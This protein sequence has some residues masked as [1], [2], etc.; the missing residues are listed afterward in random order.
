MN[1]PGGDRTF[2]GGKDRGRRSDS[3]GS[4]PRRPGQGASGQGASGHGGSGHGASG[5][6]GSKHGGSKP[7]GS[8]HGGSKHGAAERSDAPRSRGSSHRDRDHGPAPDPEARKRQAKEREERAWKEPVVRPAQGGEDLTAR[9]AAIHLLILWDL[10]KRAPMETL[11]GEYL[12]GV[13]LSPSDRGFLTEL[14]YGAVRQRSTLRALSEHFLERPLNETHRSLRAA[15]GIGL[16]QRVYL[17]TPPHAV[18]DATIEGWRSLAP[19]PSS[20]VQVDGAAGLLNAVLRRACESI[21][22][23]PLNTEPEDPTEVVRAGDRW[24]HVPGLG[25]PEHHRAELLGVQYSHPTEM[26]RLWLERYDTATLRRILERNNRTPQL[27]IAPRSDQ[28][29]EAFL[30]L[31]KVGGIEAT[32]VGDTDLPILRILTPTPIERIPGFANGSFWVQDRT[33]RRLAAMMP[34]RKGVTLL[35]LCAAPG[36]KLATLLDRGG[37]ERVVACDVSEEK[38]R[39]LA[40]NLTRLRFE[41]KGIGLVEISRE[42]ERLRFDMKFD[43]I[44]VD[45]PCSNTGVLARRHEARW[46]F[47]PEEM[48]SLTALQH[49][50]LEAAVRHL[51]PGGDLLY[52]TCSIEPSENGDP[53][54]DLLARHT[55]VRLVEEVEVLPGDEDGDGGYGALLRRDRG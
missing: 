46:R 10:R 13:Q 25:L 15:L 39:R 29:P 31:L 5:H 37:I 35:D 48:R 28:E 16:Y 17:D 40:E 36:G 49:G 45:A 52:T 26:V 4:A 9:A 38:L 7:G 6:G 42:S 51:A 41:S 8:K 1:R 43:Q 24:V 50:L 47:L 23:L 34:H 11:L 27:F 18:V 30:R 2:G 54:H 44:L 33:A 20:K 14:C 12:D 32:Q 53:I 22:R 3:G 19:I 55:Q 21:T